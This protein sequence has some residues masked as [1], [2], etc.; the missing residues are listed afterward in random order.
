MSDSDEVPQKRIRLEET[1][2][3]G[4]LE[5]APLQLRAL[6]DAR[7]AYPGEYDI[8]L[9]SS[10]EIPVGYVG[11]ISQPTKRNWKRTHYR[12]VSRVMPGKKGETLDF[13]ALA[14]IDA[15]SIHPGDHIADLHLA[16]LADPSLIVEK[17]VETYSSEEAEKKEEGNLTLETAAV[18]DEDEKIKK[19]ENLTLEVAAIEPEEEER[20]ETNVVIVVD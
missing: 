16:K 10:Y 20:K 14:F 11:V 13:V 19:E 7:L 8:V 18:E 2:P 1:A 12:A 17:D 5:Y 15:G 6:R 4:G 3:E 9:S